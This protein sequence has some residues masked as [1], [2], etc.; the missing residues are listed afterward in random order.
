M[1]KSLTPPVFGCAPWFWFPLARREGLGK[2]YTVT[3]S[4]LLLP[5]V[6]AVCLLVGG[7][8]QTPFIRSIKGVNESTRGS[9]LF[10]YLLGASHHRSYSE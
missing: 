3:P 1:P 6:K 8:P 2:Q 4:G 10:A 5:S 9:G 7:V